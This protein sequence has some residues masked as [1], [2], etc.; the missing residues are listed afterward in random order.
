MVWDCLG[1]DKH[2]TQDCETPHAVTL[3]IMKGLF[4]TVLYFNK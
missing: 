4:K 2:H 1:T 3:S